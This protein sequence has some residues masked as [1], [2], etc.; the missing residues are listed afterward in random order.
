VQWHSSSLGLL[1][2]MLH[3]QFENVRDKRR[4]GGCHGSKMNLDMRQFVMLLAALLRTA[5]V[6][7]VV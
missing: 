5:S 1:V 4:I 2:S 6:N 3:I 7:Y